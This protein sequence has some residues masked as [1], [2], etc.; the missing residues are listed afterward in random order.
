MLMKKDQNTV[1]LESVSTENETK[2]L[3]ELKMTMKFFKN[4]LQIKK[5]KHPRKI[6]V[7]LC[8]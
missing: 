6:W 5:Y 4:T 8:M 7:F 3:I 2:E 1:A